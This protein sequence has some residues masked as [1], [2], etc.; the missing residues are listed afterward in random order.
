MD[1]S[2]INWMSL[3]VD[4]VDHRDYPDFCDAYFSYGEDNTGREL[5]E[6]ELIHLTEN[7]P[8]TLHEMAFEALI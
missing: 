7:A 4:G 6:D 3:E 2:T 1:F 5:T 8:A